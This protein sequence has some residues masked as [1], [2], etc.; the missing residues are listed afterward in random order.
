[1]LPTDHV[2]DDWE[3]CGSHNR[4]VTIT[5]ILVDVEDLSLTSKIEKL[6]FPFVFQEQS[7]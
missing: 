3:A 5:V 6:E 2:A 4:A 1:M 7:P